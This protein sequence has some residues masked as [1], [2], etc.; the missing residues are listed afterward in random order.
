MA[1]ENRTMQALCVLARRAEM[2]KEKSD[3]RNAIL[4]VEELRPG[5]GRECVG[6]MATFVAEEKSAA[7]RNSE[8][9][10]RDAPATHG[11][12]AY[13]THVEVHAARL[14][15]RDL[16]GHAQ[17]RTNAG[18]E[19]VQL[20]AVPAKPFAKR[21]EKLDARTHP[22][23]GGIDRANE[24][25][26]VAIRARIAQ[27]FER[28]RAQ[29]IAVGLGSIGK[30]TDGFT[31]KLRAL[32]RMREVDIGRAR[33]ANQELAPGLDRAIP[34]RVAVPPDIRR[35]VARESATDPREL[36]W[37]LDLLEE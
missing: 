19:D 17:R 4:E 33:T 32:P 25:H 11:V 36:Q 8:A 16:L 30:I 5:I 31:E 15:D 23:E 29:V 3:A 12:V 1:F 34:G 26:G 7:G 21:S 20:H 27:R 37:T 35:A 2:L 24:A 13:R 6:G 28:A 22:F 10:L 14:N 9:A 18:V